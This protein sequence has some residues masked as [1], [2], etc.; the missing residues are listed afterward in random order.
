MCA[1]VMLL[2]PKERTKKRLCGGM[3]HKK[4][5]R[6]QN[7][8]GRRDQHSPGLHPASISRATSSAS[9]SSGAGSE[10]SS[11]PDM[12]DVDCPLGSVSNGCM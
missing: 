11:A 5:R 10:A 12:S 4:R 7:G 1:L 2:I 3:V 8:G 9:L 6:R